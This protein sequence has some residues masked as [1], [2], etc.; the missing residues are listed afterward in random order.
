MNYRLLGKTGLKVSEISLG[1]W[2]VGGVWGMGFDHDS[3]QELLQAAYE[4]GVNFFD[5]A[6]VYENGESEKAVG[7]FLKSVGSSEE[8]FVATKCGKQINPFINEN[9]SPEVLRGYV[10]DSLKR[11]KPKMDLIFSTFSEPLSLN[12]KI[13]LSGI[14]DKLIK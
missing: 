12:E 9:F 3:A 10:E 8:L 2:Q 13:Q 5:T 6:D 1:T 11:L 4:S 14:L 7:K